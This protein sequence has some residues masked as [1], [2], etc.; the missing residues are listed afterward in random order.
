MRLKNISWKRSVALIAAACTLG[1]C[2]IAGSIAWANGEGT[3]DAGA[4]TA[5]IVKQNTSITIH[6]LQGPEIAGLRSNGEDYSDSNNANHDKVKD[7]LPVEGV[8]FTVTRVQTSDSKD[9]DLATVKGWKSIAA[10]SD[11]AN[12]DKKA[13][14]FL[15]G[16]SPLFK[17]SETNTDKHVMK[18]DKDGLAKFP[19]LPEGL[20]YVVESN[21]SGAKLVEKNGNKK[22]VTITGSVVP[23][24]VTTPLPKSDKSGWNYDIHIFPKN[25]TS[26]EQP[27]K[28]L[29][30]ISRLDVDKD[31]NTTLPWKITIPLV[32]PENGESYKKIG[33][34]DPLQ[35]TLTYKKVKDVNLVFGE[36]TEPLTLNT[37]YTVTELKK[38]DTNKTVYGVRVE[39]TDA[40][41]AKAAAKF[42][43]YKDDTNAN[44]KP[45]VLEATVVTSAKENIAN[46]LNAINTWSDEKYKTGD[47]DKPDPQ[48]CVPTATNPCDKYT[49]KDKA[50]FA[51]L[52]I[53][54]INDGK[55][56]AKKV[57]NGA[58]F[59][60]YEVNK[61]VDINNITLE[62]YK[63]NTKPVKAVSTANTPES[64]KT[65]NDGTATI[66][67]FVGN[68]DT[69]TKGYCLIETEAPAGFKKEGTPHCYNLMA[70]TD[71]QAKAATATNGNSHE[72][73]NSHATELDKILAALPM[74]GARGLV[75]LTVCGIVGIVGTF[76]YIVMKRRKE[77]EQE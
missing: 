59:A 67:L 51:R 39:L 2:C 14:D 19:D 20:Y 5:N 66:K 34:S 26:E 53:T 56:T 40:G 23:F 12:K 72:I 75:I 29:G 43:A 46:A 21:T 48:P 30:D 71:E 9:I 25:D 54:K 63:Q 17:L 1:T 76:F 7:K 31:G 73:V 11:A 44:K 22:D 45:A 47:G 69:T 50:H 42:K 61:G 18:T 13:A 24:F 27:T 49:G 32:S 60:I 37:D 10:I 52:K 15:S 58:E 38:T 6:K 55:G 4:N 65:E 62:N 3:Q 41:L 16:K 35:D 8:E 64:I 77:Q 36:S 70:E 28:V 33:F 68:G 57:L 74:T